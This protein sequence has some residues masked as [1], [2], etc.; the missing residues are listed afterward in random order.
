MSSTNLLAGFADLSGKISSMAG[1]ELQ[2]A[3]FK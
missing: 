2:L 1:L 3:I